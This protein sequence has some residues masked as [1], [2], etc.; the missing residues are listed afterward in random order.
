MDGVSIGMG[1][2]VGFVIGIAAGSE[3]GRKQCIKRINRLMEQGDIVIH[4]ASGDP[5]SAVELA[6]ILKKTKN[7]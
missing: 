2:A 3:S 6:H 7:K 4:S 1:I 5:V